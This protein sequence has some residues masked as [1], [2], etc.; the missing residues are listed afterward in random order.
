MTHKERIGKF[1]ETVFYHPDFSDQKKRPYIMARMPN[2]ELYLR[3]KEKIMARKADSILFCQEPVLTSEQE[4][5]EFRKYN[6]LKWITAEFLKKDN[7]K[8]AIRYCDQAIQVRNL[9]ICS[10]LRLCLTA[11]KKLYG[12]IKDDFISE[13]MFGLNRI[14]NAF[15]WQ[16]GFKFSTYATWALKNNMQRLF[17]N[18]MQKNQRFEVSTLP[19]YAQDYRNYEPNAVLEQKEIQFYIQKA[20]RFL[21]E[22]Q[23]FVLEQRY[24]LLPIKQSNSKKSPHK[25]TLLQIGE[26]FSERFGKAI[27]RERVRQI[28]SE[29][30]IR[31]RKFLPEGLFV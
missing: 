13:A 11:T 22:E 23:R 25:L 2:Y 28:E 19:D 27:T 26:M 31:M 30:F 12:D 4:F 9:L 6:F 17:A 5:H 29:G 15:D 14:V 16:R 3:N 18:T 1:V 10:N 7:M 20:M 8:S 21:P 24:D